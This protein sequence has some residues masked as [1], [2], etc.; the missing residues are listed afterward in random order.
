MRDGVVLAKE[1]LFLD[2]DTEDGAE[3]NWDS[4][5]HT[6]V[7]VPETKS[8]DQ[9][10]LMF[11][12]KRNHLAVVVDE[13]GGVQ[14]VVTLEDV[15]EEIVGEIEDETDSIERLIVRR[16]DG[17]L[18]CRGRAETRKLFKTLDVAE[19]PEFVT[20]SG[21]V[22]ALLGHVPLEGDEVSWK[23]LHFT[24][25]R[26]TKRRAERIEVRMGKDVKGSGE[27]Q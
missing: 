7:V 20:V 18:L 13:Y 17:V 26:A 23:Q 5:K 4:L 22:S 15:L 11:Q 14:G 6:M 27:E 9:L 8:L 1:L 19:K 2:H 25:V 3:P 16:P 21:M 10:L 12:D 24:V